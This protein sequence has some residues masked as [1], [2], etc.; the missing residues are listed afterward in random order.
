VGVTKRSLNIFLKPQEL[1]FGALTAFRPVTNIGILP[2]VALFILVQIYALYGGRPVNF[3]HT[4]LSHVL[5][6]GNRH[7]PCS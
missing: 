5:E 4:A 1:K 2:G 3:Y 6:D 7:V